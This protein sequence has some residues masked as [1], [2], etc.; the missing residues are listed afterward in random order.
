[1]CSAQTEIYPGTNIPALIRKYALD[2]SHPTQ[3]EAWRMVQEQ[4]G[5][6]PPRFTDSLVDRAVK[7]VGWRDINF[8][9]NVEALRAHFMKIYQQFVDRE[10]NCG[11]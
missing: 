8:S 3:G 6:T 11:P 2:D 7:C 5:R 9:E 10:R 4:I 1:M